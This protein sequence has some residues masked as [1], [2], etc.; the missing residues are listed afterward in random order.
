[1][2]SSSLEGWGRAMLELQQCIYIIAASGLSVGEVT[3][4]RAK[5]QIHISPFVM[6]PYSMNEWLYIFGAAL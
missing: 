1:M 2:A 4:R 3:W 5:Q 6:T